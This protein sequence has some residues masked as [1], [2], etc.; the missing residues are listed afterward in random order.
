MPTTI[1]FI[2][3]PALFGN[4]KGHRSFDGTVDFS[5]LSVGDMCYYH[6]RGVPID[7]VEHMKRCLHLSNNY[8]TQNAMRPPLILALPDHA[9]SKALYFLVDGQCYSSKCKVCGVSHRKC[10]C[11][12]GKYDPRGYYDGWTVTGSPPLIT[13]APSINFDDDEDKIKHYHGFVQNGIIGDG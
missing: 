12:D 3:K 1:R 8:W 6:W 13:V 2:E 9:N 7:N 10:V 5:K 4:N 11:G